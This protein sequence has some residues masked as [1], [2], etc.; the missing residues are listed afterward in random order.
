MLK[1]LLHLL[2]GVSTFSDVGL[3]TPSNLAIVFGPNLMKSRDENPMLAIA[4][5]QA[6]NDLMRG[7]IE[8]YQYFIADIQ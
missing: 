3:M 1:R 5:S 8:N 2:H 4:D 7:L 6:V